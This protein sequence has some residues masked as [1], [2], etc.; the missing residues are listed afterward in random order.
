VSKGG[1]NTATHTSTEKGEVYL[2]YGERF[3]SQ[4][5]IRRFE[6]IRRKLEHEDTEGFEAIGQLFHVGSFLV[7]SQHAV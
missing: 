2:R 7:Q 6:E 4:E 5:T 3:Y 1:T